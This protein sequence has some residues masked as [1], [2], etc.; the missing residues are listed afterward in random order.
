MQKANQAKTKLN[1][2]RF[3]FVVGGQQNCGTINLKHSH[4]SN[5]RGNI[6]QRYGMVF[7]IHSTLI[8]S[9]HSMNDIFSSHSYFQWPSSARPINSLLKALMIGRTLFNCSGSPY[10]KAS[11]QAAIA[12]HPPCL[13]ASPPAI[14]MTLLQ[15]H[16]HCVPHSKH[17]YS[18]QTLVLQRIQV[19]Q[20]GWLRPEIHC[21]PE[22]ADFER[23]PSS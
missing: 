3:P 18:T 14:P 16:T 10:T 7:F 20:W 8:G 5:E 2:S 21:G 19:L 1:R 11:I 22:K 12:A 9:K 6:P 23:W 4:E 17:I 15:A 13:R